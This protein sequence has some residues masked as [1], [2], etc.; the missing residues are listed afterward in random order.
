M[1]RTQGDRK[2]IIPPSR[3]TTIAGSNPASMISIPNIFLHLSH[4]TSLVTGPSGH[5]LVVIVWTAVIRRNIS[6]P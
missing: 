3:A 1:G 2:L 5:I 6:Y 4:R